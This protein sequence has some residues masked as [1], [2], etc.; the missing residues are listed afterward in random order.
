MQGGKLLSTL[1][2]VRGSAATSRMS[3]FYRRIFVRELLGFILYLDF[4]DVAI[5][6]LPSSIP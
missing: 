3:P 6:I 1:H 5:N 4:I 2:S